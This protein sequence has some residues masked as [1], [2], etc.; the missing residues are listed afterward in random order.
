MLTTEGTVSSPHPTMRIAFS[1]KHTEIARQQ[2]EKS[3]WTTHGVMSDNSSKAT[4]P[5]FEVE[6]NIRNHTPPTMGNPMSVVIGA[7]NSVL[8]PSAPSISSSSSPHQDVTADISVRACHH[9]ANVS[10]ANIHSLTGSRLTA[11]SAS[12]SV[13][14]SLA[15][16]T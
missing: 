10:L 13:A 15:S 12:S 1:Y 14:R 16:I 11:A 7:E 6:N 2:W 9:V 5:S 8:Q 4:G 3:C